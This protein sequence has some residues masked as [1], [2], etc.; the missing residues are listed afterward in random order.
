[1]STSIIPHFPR[2]LHGGDYNPDQWLRYPEILREDIRLIG[3]SGCNTLTVG[4]FA[5]TALEPA[6]GQYHLTWLDGV[7]DRLNEAG[8][9][10]ILATPSAARPAWMAQKYPEIRRI[11]RNGLREPHQGRHNFCWSS[12]VYREKVRQ[13]NTLLAR[14]YAR[15]PA[16]G[17]WHLSNE[18]AGTSRGGECLCD[19]CLQQWQAW[20]QRRYG[21]LE[22]LNHAWWTGFWSHTFTDWSQIT[23]HDESVDGMRLDW[24]RFVNWQI[25]DFFQWE[26]RPLRELTPQVPVTTN[27][28]GVNPDIDYASFAEVVDVVSDDQYPRYEDDDPAELV[29]RARAIAFKHDYYR[30]FKKNR[31]FFLM[32]SCPDGVQWRTPQRAKPRKLHFLE[33]LQALGHG[34]EGTCYFQWRK[35]RGGSEKFHGAVV[36]HEGSEKGRVFQNVQALSQVYEQLTPILGSV[37]A[38]AEA[39]VV[40]DWEAWRAFDYASGPQNKDDAYRKVAQQ[41]HLAL[42]APGRMVDVIGSEADFSGYRLLVL[43]QLFLLHPGVASRLRSFVENGGTL[44]ATPYTGIVNA[45]GLVFTGG[46]PGDGL[47]EVFGLWYEEND[48]LPEGL[49]RPVRMEDGWRGQ[50]AELDQGQTVCALVHPEGASVTGVF[51]G[52]FYRGQAAITR[53][54]WGR[55]QAWFLGTHFE[56]AFLRRFYDHFQLAHFFGEPLPT[57]VLAQVREKENRRYYFLQNCLK[58][59]ASISLGH[60]RLQSLL[61][62]QPAETTLRLPG[63]GSGVWENIA[64]GGAGGNAEGRR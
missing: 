32:E 52:G 43:P 50:L 64:D 16:L 55:G 24:I 19:L 63:W 10:V 17:L 15:H 3:L 30:N 9:K 23:P 29:N 49:H 53:H 41:H 39:A 56:G 33:M 60:L 59:E 5:W 11:L 45:S 28:M 14:R 25:R 31:S 61:D 46:W 20:L 54:G 34:A 58:H 38:R 21:T 26:A 12:P 47:R 35:G 37:P 62:R 13:I 4:I 40:F 48:A 7:M 57:G 18:Y 51:E 36:D 27:F 6:E 8:V 42:S 2:L 44:V 22:E 1:M